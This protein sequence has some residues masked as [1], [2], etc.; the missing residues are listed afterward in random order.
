MNEHWPRWIFASISKHFDANR[1]SLKLHIEGQYRDT[2][3]EQDF[4]E[5]RLNGPE[6][7][8]LSKNYWRIRVRVN[9]LVQSVKNETNFHR[10]HTNVGIVVKAFDTINIK[11]YGDG[12][13]DDDSLL[14]CLKLVQEPGDEPVAVHHFGQVDPSTQLV[15]AA[16]EGLYEMHLTS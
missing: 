8:E 15:Q 13:D 11:K 3:S 10:I 12:V 5:L 4:I 14:G 1:G 6:F 9:V 7:T 2:R 16:V